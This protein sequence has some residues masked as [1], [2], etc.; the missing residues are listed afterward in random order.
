MDL[1]RRKFLTFTGTASALGLAGCLDPEEG[2]SWDIWLG[3]DEPD[4]GQPEYSNERD[5]HRDERSHERFDG[6]CDTRFRVPKHGEV[7]FFENPELTDRIRLEG[8]ISDDGDQGLE[9]QYLNQVKYIRGDGGLLWD[10]ECFDYTPGGFRDVDYGDWHSR[11]FELMHEYED[12]YLV[13]SYA[14]KDVAGFDEKRR[15]PICIYESD[16]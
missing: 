1:S 2:S 6:F 7:Y 5:F 16:R 10:A 15:V 11:C 4:E 3:G 9:I 13:R 14:V 8:A 12:S